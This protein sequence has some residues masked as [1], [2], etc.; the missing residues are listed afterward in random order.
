MPAVLLP[1]FQIL[2]LFPLQFLH[3]HKKKKGL[4]KRLNKMIDEK[5]T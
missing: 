1:Q 2:H 4:L 3:V 5:K